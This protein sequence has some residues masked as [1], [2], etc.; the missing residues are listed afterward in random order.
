[1]QRITWLLGNPS[2]EEEKWFRRRNQAGIEW[3]KKRPFF[4]VTK[5]RKMEPIKQKDRAKL[6]IEK[7]QIQIATRD[8]D[9]CI[10]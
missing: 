3:E 9:C 10:V 2:K 6:K 4:L 5:Q 8:F 1:M 7:A